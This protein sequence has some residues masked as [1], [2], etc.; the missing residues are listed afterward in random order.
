[1]AEQL[2]LMIKRTITKITSQNDK[3]PKKKLPKVE[4]RDDEIL[5][6]LVDHYY[7]LN[8]KDMEKKGPVDDDTKSFVYEQV[9]EYFKGKSLQGQIGCYI[10]TFEEIPVLPHKWR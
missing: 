7:D 10:K 8:I 6:C 9:K 3:T 1:M 5:Y 4:K 2:E